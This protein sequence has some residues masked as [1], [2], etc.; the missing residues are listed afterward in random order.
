MPR[1]V[2]CGRFSAHC[3][4]VCPALADADFYAAAQSPIVGLIV[5]QVSEKGNN[6]GNQLLVEIGGLAHGDNSA[7]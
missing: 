1:G 5:E 6:L 4:Q 7:V 3:R 2:F